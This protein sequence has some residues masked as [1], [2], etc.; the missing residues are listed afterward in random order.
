MG[1]EGFYNFCV[2]VSGGSGCLIQPATDEYSFV[3]TAAHVIENLAAEDIEVVRQTLG[4][5]G[6][7]NNETIEVIEVFIHPDVGRDAAILKVPYQDGVSNLFR[8]YEE[9]FAA[10]RDGFWL[11]GHPAE[12]SANNYSYRQ[13]PIS[14]INRSALNYWEGEVAGYAGF[15][16]VVGQS[17][18]AILKAAGDFYLIAGIQSRMSAPDD[19][20]TGRV[21]FMPVS[22]FDEIIAASGGQ[23]AELYPIY[24][25]SFEHLKTLAMKL[26]GS[27]PDLPFTRGYLQGL[28]RRVVERGLTP[29]T[30]K[31]AFRRRLLVFG[32]KDSAL[33]NRGLWTAWL[34]LLI[35]L[36]VMQVLEAEGVELESLFNRTRLIFS[37]TAEDWVDEISA[38]IRSDFNGL[39]EDGKIIVATNGAAA[40]PRIKSK[41]LVSNIGKIQLEEFQIDRPEH[42][43]VK[44]DLV[45]LRAFQICVIRAAERYVDY[46]NASIEDLLRQLREDYESELR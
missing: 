34:E 11:I 38:I 2:K 15:D 40:I 33:N 30:I 24:L 13:N 4:A 23:M 43:L 42:P 14:I 8:L 28:T 45:H 7:V 21:D 16:D 37:E 20:G 44:S 46:D 18:G 25:D 10:D 3:L 5:R 36:Q 19:N 26:V 35:I 22:F 29:K 31:E 1:V 41:N 9:E 27:F 17:G 12:R 32:Q 6:A 39:A